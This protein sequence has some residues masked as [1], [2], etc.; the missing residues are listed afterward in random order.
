MKHKQILA[1][2]CSQDT[3]LMFK[4]HNQGINKDLFDSVL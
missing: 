3:T 4:Y 1:V 2:N